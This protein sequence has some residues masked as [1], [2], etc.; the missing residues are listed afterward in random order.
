M[1]KRQP[2]APAEELPQLAIATR[3][4]LRAWL[5]EHHATSPGVWLVTTK[6]AAGGVVAWNDIV[7]EALCF[8][9]IDSLPRALDETRTM[10]RLTPRRAGSAW[11]AKNKGHVEALMARGAMHAA[12]LAAVESAKASGA[13]SVL[14]AASAL[15]VPDDLAAA[16][17]SLPPA[18]E[19]FDAFPPSARRGILE[20]LSL[21]KRPATRA[22]RVQSIAQAAQENRRANAWPR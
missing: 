8:G 13:W 9:W 14:D 12:G 11:S 7:E 1:A 22:A 2:K 3:A 18:R 6:K 17:A 16:L 19:H 15:L 5:R 4:E 21:A 20:W 10:L